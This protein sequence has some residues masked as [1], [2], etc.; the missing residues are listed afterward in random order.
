MPEGMI[1][2][3]TDLLACFES[4]CRLLWGFSGASTV[5]NPPAVQEMQVQSL[6]RE[7]PLEKGLA[8]HSS[9][10]A[11]EIPWTEGPGRLQSTGS[12]ESNMT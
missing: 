1:S 11:W 9:I 6:G 4:P 8:T 7:N 2:P 5:K 12:K 10:L 3:V